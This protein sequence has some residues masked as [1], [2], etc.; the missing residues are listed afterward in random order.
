[1]R[2]LLEHPISTQEIVD[3]L[4]FLMKEFNYRNTESC[5]DMGPIIL[6]EA[7]ARIVNAETQERTSPKD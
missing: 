3:Y 2:N 4:S 5:G 6:A 7:I 1:M